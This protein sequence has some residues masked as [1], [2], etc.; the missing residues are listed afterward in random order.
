MIQDATKLGTQPDHAYTGKCPFH[1]L[2]VLLVFTKGSPLGSLAPRRQAAPSPS[3]LTVVWC[4]LVGGDDDG[5]RRRWG[6]RMVADE[7]R[8][9]RRVPFPPTPHPSLLLQALLPL[10]SFSFGC[11]YKRRMPLLH[12]FLLLLPSAPLSYLPI[13]LLPLADPPSRVAIGGER[14]RGPSLGTLPLSPTPL[15]PL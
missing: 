15:K 11:S 2:A 14:K 5:G 7:G 10:S 4:V 6:W 3:L 1:L 13:C 12:I 8:D 9:R